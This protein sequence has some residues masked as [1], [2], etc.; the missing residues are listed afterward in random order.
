MLRFFIE[1]TL[2]A[3]S[4]IKDIADVRYD[5]VRLFEASDG[6]RGTFNWRHVLLISNLFDTCVLNRIFYVSPAFFAD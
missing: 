4:A 2:P 3:W 6:T 1:H 5:C